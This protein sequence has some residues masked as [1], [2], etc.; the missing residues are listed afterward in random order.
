[1]YQL[2]QEH[3]RARCNINKLLFAG[4]GESHLASRLHL[5]GASPG[6]LG[7]HL[8]AKCVQEISW[9]EKMCPDPALTAHPGLKSSVPQ[10]QRREFGNYGCLDTRGCS[11]SMEKCFNNSHV[12]LEV[13][14]RLKKKKIGI[15]A[16][17]ATAQRNAQ[18]V[19]QSLLSP[20]FFFFSLSQIPAK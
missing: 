15:K 2:E 19:L 5:S 8:G 6:E 17:L 4:G 16:C 20:T 10:A 18:E 13:G 11:R 14:K 3:K 7:S 9:L 1:M 12:P